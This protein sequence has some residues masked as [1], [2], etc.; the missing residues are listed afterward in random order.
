MKLLYQRTI[1]KLLASG[2]LKTSDHVLVVCGGVFDAEVLRDSGFHNVEISNLDSDYAPIVAPYS[3]SRQDAENLS[4]ADDSFDVAIVHAGLHH[5]YSPHRALLEMYR[6][7]RRAV[8][9]IESRDNF[10][11]NVAKQLGLTI[12]YEIEGISESTR[13]GGVAGGSIPNFIYRWKEAEVT[14]T[15]ACFDPVRRTSIDFFYGLVL[16]V[17]RL[18]VTNN[19]LGQLLAAIIGPFGRLFE[20]T[21]PRQCNHFGFLVRKTGELWPWIEKVDGEYTLDFGWVKSHGRF[22]S[23]GKY[24]G[25]GNP[26]S[27]K[28]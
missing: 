9:V 15:I 17:E 16:P 5:C 7:A 21:F 6:V 8:L 18:R 4:Y 14:K 25:R 13:Q 11:I 26:R 3:W 23:Q 22:N 2:E 20:A 10:L 19:K 28:S 12:D 1:A 27:G 24:M